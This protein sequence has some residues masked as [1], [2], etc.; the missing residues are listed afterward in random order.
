FDCSNL[1]SN[2]V[3]L[4]VTDANGNSSTADASVIVQDNEDPVIAAVSEI[5]VSNLNGECRAVV[6]VNNPVVSDNCSIDSVTG[7]RDDGLAITAYYPLGTTVIT[8][9]AEDINGNQ[10]EPITQNIIV[11]DNEAPVPPTINNIEWGCEYTAEIPVA[12]DN[13]DGNVTGTT[14]DPITFDSNGNYTIDWKFT[15]DA[16][17]TSNV[18]QNISID[19]LEQTVSQVNVDCNN[20]NTGSATATALGGIKPY[21]Y[22]WNTLGTG[23]I[24]T[25]LSEGTYYVT[26]SDANNC[27]VTKE[28]IISQ[29]DAL[30]INGTTSQPTS[31]YDNGTNNIEDGSISVGDVS[32]GTPPYQYSLDNENFQS[33]TE[34]TGVRADEYTVFV[35]DSNG[36]AL[37]DF[38]TVD[39][40]DEVSANISKA[41]LSCNGDSSGSINI[42][43]AAGGSGEYEYSI[44]NNTWQSE[45]N[46][47]G[48]SI[49]DYSVYIRD[50][51]S[52]SC[53]ILLDDALKITQPELLTATATSTRTTAYGSATGS[54]TANPAG[55]TPGY[56]YEWRKLDDNN[57]P[58]SEVLAN[59]KSINNIPAGNYQVTVTDKN[60]CKATTSKEVIDKVFVEIIASSLCDDVE[61]ELRTSRFS[62]NLETIAGG[63]GPVTEFTYSWKF[64]TS[65]RPESTS[66]EGEIKVEYDQPGDKDIILTVTDASGISSDYQFIHY[67]GKCFEDCGQ[68]QNFQI[69]RNSFYIGD[70]SGNVID[71]DN[72]SQ[73]IEKF[74][75]FEITKSSNIYALNTELVYTITDENGNTTEKKAIDCFGKDLDSRSNKIEWELIPTGLYRLFK[76]TES[77]NLDTEIEW[78]CGSS[79]EIEALSMRYVTN[80]KKECGDTNRNACIGLSDEVGV[81]T[82][83]IANAQPTDATCF[84]TDTGSISF[85]ASGGIRPYFYSI[86]GDIEDNYF[87][88]K[89]FYNLPAGVYSNLWVK[90]NLG[91]KIQLPRVEI[92]EPSE[93]ELEINLVNDPDC[94][95]VVSAK[96]EASGGTP[97]SSG[98]NY[99]WNDEAES[100]EQTV[101][102]SP[103][104]YTVTVTDANDCQEISYI[105]ISEPEELTTPEAGDNQELG[106]GIFSTTLSANNPENGIGNWSIDETN[107]DSGGSITNNSDNE[108]VFSSEGAGS[109]TLIWT[110]SNADGQ[111][112][113]SDSV[114]INFSGDCNNL[115]FDGV[116]DYIG[117][118]DNYG[119]TS[120]NFTIELW[121]KPENIT[122]LKTILSK[123]DKAANSVGYD[124]ILNGGSPTFRWGSKSATTSRKLTTAR[125]HHIAVV[126]KQNSARL[127]V[128][129]IDIGN[130]NGSNNPAVTAAPFLLGAIYDSSTPNNPKDY[131]SGWME[132]LRIWKTALTPKNIRFMMNQRLKIP[133][134]INSTTIIEGKEIPNKSIAGSYYTANDL[135]LDKDGEPFYNLTWGNLAGYYP[136]ISIDPDPLNILDIDENLK[137]SNGSTPDLAINNIP[138]RL[139]NIETN[140]NNTAP[141]PY[142]SIQDGEWSLKTTW[143][144]PSVWD[145]PNSHGIDN[146]T[147]IDWNIARIK[148]KIS[149]GKDI[150]LLGLYSES[151]ELEMNGT[152]KMTGDQSGT[153]T[154]NGL[155]ISHYLK[156]DG[157]IDLNGESQL[158][159]PQGSILDSSSSGSI[160]IDQQGTANSFNYNYWTSPVSLTGGDNNSGFKIKE[161]LLD[162]SDLETPKALSFN[163]QYHWADYYDSSQERRISTYWFNTFQGTA[164]DYFQWA[165][166]AETDLLLP[167]IGYTMKGTKGY[168][169]ISDRQNYTFRGKPNNGDISVDVAPNQNLLTGNPYP[170]AIDALDFIQDNISDFNG[171]LYFWDHFGPVNSHYLEEYIGGYAVYNLSGGI[172]TASSI[173]SRINTDTDLKG[174]KRPGQFI[175][176]GQAFFINTKGISNPAAITFK[177][178]HRVFA[179]ESE[180]ESQFHSQEDLKPKRGQE[181]TGNKKDTRYKIRLKFESPK[182]YHRQIL[183]AADTRSTN[184]FDLGFDAPYIENNVEDMYW[185]INNEPFVIQGVPNFNL[186]QVLSLGI[187]IDEPGA[188]TIK[189]DGLENIGSD[190]NIYLK[191]LLNGSY[192]KISE[193]PYKDTIEETG[194]FNDRFQLVF[195]NPQLNN[196]VKDEID[197][198][199]EN[200]SITLQYSKESD[201]ISL[202]NPER[203][204]IDLI[205]LYSIT[206]QK[207]KTFSEFPSEKLITLSIDLKLSSAVY[208]L[209]VYSGEKFYSK[210]LIISK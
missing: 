193:E 141:L 109:Y 208:V 99:L 20:S 134:N 167:G 162:A 49:G 110:I 24:K 107:S 124:L 41:N 31:C 130:A 65:A 168:V 190:F 9:N 25:G 148:N 118:T 96:A 116:D 42:S 140:Q 22:T 159:Q 108:S 152:I 23:A 38:I 122:G 3:T 30:S 151:G 74:L 146:A 158:V 173:D 142:I 82:P 179:T 90:D 144:R 153:G 147:A 68:S 45:N 198:E 97:G 171:S 139:Y 72:C 91:K 36:C 174:D 77:T 53:A 14:T 113:K 71:S 204:D 175:P 185:L 1:G 88:T 89:D 154:G 16:G 210:K 81:S 149:S 43:N 114:T 8:W 135:N 18:T 44:D 2:T 10:A 199:L 104:D 73:N 127:F 47:A 163:Y 196:P 28:V 202:Y 166:V 66:G 80:D 5:T 7:T 98:Y 126:F 78:S 112:P 12:V 205:E 64:G 59:T 184:G 115:D 46:F 169:P 160:D 19:L 195:R 15:D 4:T 145:N 58:G 121:V 206:G 172:S 101:A 164:D 137:P 76:I 48:L 11:L 165:Q 84:M 129:G 87:N 201:E 40:P 183:A 191:D 94:Y 21:T 157:S 54:A 119:F 39:Q 29:P 55:G 181:G 51:L 86:D 13:C 63:V 52:P 136:M 85:S 133:D 178:K 128:D 150:K 123:K 182:G 125:W 209:K 194:V 95:G 120:G 92:K 177:N 75:W 117:M 203:L 106:C 60:G 180:D 26:V 155:T 102:L 189:I 143:L 186:D 100:T 93:I 37:Q 161:I 70:G 131:Y 50:R 57:N 17:N 6:T 62:V 61:N 176:V 34:F 103:G 27:K 35:V 105:N 138:G 67:A 132:E 79:F 33:S 83:I 56:T 156:L 200:T 170:S 187:R 32:G 111:C 69:D 192:H 197:P 207:I 188:Y